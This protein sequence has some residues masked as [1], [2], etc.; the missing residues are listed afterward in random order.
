LGLSMF[1]ARLDGLVDECC[2]L[3]SGNLLTR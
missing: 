1:T 2:S 3:V